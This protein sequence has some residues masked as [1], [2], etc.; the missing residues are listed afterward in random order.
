MRTK[1]KT[2]AFAV[3]A[4]ILASGA[5]FAQ[6]RGPSIPYNAPAVPPIGPNLPGVRC[7]TD[8]A[9]CPSVF[10]GDGVSPAQVFATIDIANCNTVVDVEVGA[11]LE[12][13][14][15][16][17]IGLTL[18]APLGPTVNLIPPPPGSG[19]DTPNMYTVLDDDA[20]EL[21]TTFCSPVPPGIEGFLQPANALNAF[22]GA[23]GNGTW[24]MQVDDWFP[25]FDGGTLEDW[26]LQ[27]ICD[28]DADL[29]LTKTG[30]ATGSAG[31]NITYSFQALNNGPANVTDMVVTDV[32]PAGVT[33]VSSTNGGCS[34][35]GGAPETVTCNLGA[36]P[37]PG[38]VLFDVTVAIDP[39]VAAGTVLTNAAEISSEVNDPV[40]GNNT[41]SVDTT[42]EAVAPITVTKTQ[43]TADPIVAGQ[44]ALLCYNVNIANA[45]PSNVVGLELEDYWG[46]YPGVDWVSGGTPCATADGPGACWTVDIPAAS[47]IN[48]QICFNV[49]AAAPEGVLNNKFSAVGSAGGEDLGN[50]ANHVS[51][52]N[53][54]ITRVAT[55]DL[56]KVETVP[57][58]GP[59]VAGS[60]AN[61]LQHVVTVSNIGPSNIDAL[62]ISD[63]LIVPAG[64]IN[65]SIVP[66]DGVFAAGTWTLDLPAG[67]VETLT[68]TGTVTLA[69]PE[70]AGI[71]VN[72]AT[73]AGSGG[74]EELLG[75]TVASADSSIRWPEATFNVTKLYNGGTGA[76]VPV[77]LDCTD[78]TGL[79]FGDPLAGA[80]DTAL[81]IKRFD[82]GLGDVTVCAVVETVP[83]GYYEAQRTAECDVGNVQDGGVYD[84]TITNLETVA[85]FNVTKDFSD[86]STDDVN[87][88]LSCDTGLPLVQDLT[89]AGGDPTG[90]TFVVTDFIDG[91]MSC[92]VTEV[93]NTPGYTIEASG[94][95]WNLVNAIDGPFSCVVNNVADDATFTAYKY[96]EIINDG[97]DYVDP[98]V[99]V[100]ISCSRD[101]TSS[102]GNIAGNQRS[103]TRVLGDGDY[104]VVTVDVETGPATCSASENITQSG[105]ES[106]D[107]CFARVLGPGDIDSCTFVN[108]VFFEG[109]P[110]LSQYG[111]ALLALLML[112]VGMVGFRRFA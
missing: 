103:A 6:D 92:A 95:E 52:A 51:I 59:I 110:T 54:P 93:T 39:A 48:D 36:V 77:A 32:L 104:L 20:L 72:T 102:N 5:A 91:T 50:P 9:G 101:I 53:T 106:E 85:R 19:C 33:F 63:N 1:T 100:T 43:L 89:I 21:V 17:D 26:S 79:F 35:D 69:A 112:G 47:D 70:G 80:T 82:H 7:V 55:I 23:V 107:N 3:T 13:A 45:G 105:V 109:I 65:A 58:A 38:D 94:C 62:Q 75:D 56:D 25:P 61:N 60:G 29:E 41:D 67:D 90:V 44:P 24:T 10:F 84:C 66:S 88:V 73:V 31:T 2:L 37:G 87:V 4:A 30:P 71:I 78:A 108:T 22:N 8:G 15:S 46:V 83:D 14:W 98:Y 57:G 74:G 97:G 76:S 86:G 96:W 99:P 111:L 42:V 40:S 34:G 49:T 81:V 28:T 27:I 11:E 18:S 68:I 12:H 64:V 16:G